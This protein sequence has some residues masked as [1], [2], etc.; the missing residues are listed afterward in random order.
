M[1]AAEANLLSRLTEGPVGAVSLSPSPSFYLLFAGFSVFFGRRTA[2][3]LGN[4]PP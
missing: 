1:A 4:T 2:W 3:M